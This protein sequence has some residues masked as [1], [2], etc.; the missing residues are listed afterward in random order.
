M[1]VLAGYAVVLALAGFIMWNYRRDLA[2]FERER[3]RWTEERREL[4]NRIQRPEY[5]PR[6][7]EPVELPER[8]EEQI[9]QER[10]WAQ[11]GQVI[12]IDDSYGLD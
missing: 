10:A 6:V 4:L 2:S 7:S 3:S 8:T 1:T 9:A 12:R 11:V 5:I